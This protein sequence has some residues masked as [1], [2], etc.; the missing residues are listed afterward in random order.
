MSRIG[1]LLRKNYGYVS[2]RNNKKP[3]TVKA[4]K[5]Q[6]PDRQI[7]LDQAIKREQQRKAK[8]AEQKKQ[9]RAETI[10]K[11]RRAIDRLR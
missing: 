2:F 6:K 8:I 1:K 3:V 11:V 7:S 9:K 5:Y 10:K 4:I